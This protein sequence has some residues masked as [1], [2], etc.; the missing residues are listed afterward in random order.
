MKDKTKRN[1]NDFG[2]YL[3]AEALISEAQLASAQA[4]AHTSGISLEQ[5]LVDLEMLG[6]EQL[7]RARAHYLDIPYVCLTNVA[8]DPSV[9]AMVDADEARASRI[10]PI[11]KKSD[12]TLRLAMADWTAA[13]R[14]AAAAIA[15][16]HKVRVAPALATEHHILQLIERWY[17]AAPDEAAA[18]VGAPARAETRS[19][20]ATELARAMAPARERAGA[21]VAAGPGSMRA[22]AD[23]PARPGPGGAGGPGNP[24]TNVPAILPPGQN[25]TRWAPPAA[26]TA[27]A[28]AGASAG[29]KRASDLFTGPSGAA[30]AAARGNMPNAQPDAIEDQQ[31]DQPIVIQFVNRIL[32][33]AINRGASDIHFE[34][35]RD[36]LDIRYRIDG[37]LHN[38][39]S[40][41]RD[42]QSACCSRVKVMAEMNIA[43]RRVPQ[44]GRIAVTIDGRS[45]DMRVSSLPCQYGESVV[46]RILD[47]GASRPS[48]DQLGFSDRNLK[49]MNSLIRKPHGIFLA[50]GPTGS[51]KTTTLYAAIQAIHTPEV[52]II[53]VEDPIEYDLDGIRQSNVHEKAGLTMARQLRA[54]LRQDPDIIYVGEIRDPE[55]AE[56]AF[57]AALTGHLVFSTLHCNDAAGAVTR[58]LNMDVDPF[59]VASSVVGVLA[60]RLVRRICTSCAQPITPNPAELLAFGVDM[61]SPEMRKAR[62]MMGTGC[63]ACDYTGYK[64]RYSVQEL[65]AM[66][67]NIGNLVLQR[68]P[69]NKIRAAA[70]AHGM[71]SM[72]SDAASKVMQGITTFEEAAKRVFI[73]TGDNDQFA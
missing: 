53:T 41:R 26:H 37:T 10:I 70:I 25:T 40:I 65:M 42:F 56:I 12:G 9:I 3:I 48:L 50:T 2:A 17:A 27:A 54:I 60:Q 49:L 31:V 68:T 66:D 59:L 24:R 6:E 16:A 44:D 39:D 13:D 22:M 57:R 33:D 28:A 67:E 7:T 43:E 62:F 36:R 45:V 4:H 64:G 8:I 61:N 35:R 11:G 52:N 63:E 47:K 5:A 71:L 30:P 51:G 19:G 18:S 55:T 14:E 29:N 15:Y 46:L 1:P 21:G 23:I 38:V 34:P 20:K 72:R 69:S 73:D 32:A 58:L